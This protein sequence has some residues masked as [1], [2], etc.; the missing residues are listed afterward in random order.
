LKDNPALAR[1]KSPPITPTMRRVLRQLGDGAIVVDD[2]FGARTE[3]FGM[4]IARVTL[5]ALVDR[6]LVVDPVPLF[7][8]D[9]GKL[10][11]DGLHWIRREWGGTADA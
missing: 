7:E 2:C 11:R 4:G 9:A 5:R 8:P 10:T 6:G 1:R 3:P